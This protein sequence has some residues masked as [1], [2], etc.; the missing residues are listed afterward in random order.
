MTKRAAILA[1][2]RTFA[3]R[4]AD[5]IS[6]L[7]RLEDGTPSCARSADGV[8]GLKLLTAAQVVELTGLPRGR[9]YQLGREGKAGAVRIG[10]RSVRFSERGLSAWLEGERS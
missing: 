7:E 9:V 5:L 10:E 8:E 1:E 2:L 3:R 6:R 4:Q